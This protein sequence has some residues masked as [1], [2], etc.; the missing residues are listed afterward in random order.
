M[1]F[2]IIVV[3]PAPAAQNLGVDL[4]QPCRGRLLAAEEQLG[5]CTTE[6]SK[7]FRLYLYSGKLTL[8][9]MYLSEFESQAV[10]SRRC[11]T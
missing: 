4:R 10:A 2:S 7:Y 1:Y 3:P 5:R 6:Q 9:A 8:A 11:G